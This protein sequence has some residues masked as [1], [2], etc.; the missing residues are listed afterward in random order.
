MATPQAAQLLRCSPYFPVADVQRSLEHYERVLGF[1]RE[2]V[3]GNP[4]EFAIVSRDGLAIMLRRVE[5]AARITPS[6]QQGGTWDAFFWVR[7]AEALH[8][9]LRRNGANIVYAPMLQKAY[10]MLEFAVRDLDG[11]VL[12]FGQQS[13]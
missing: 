2:Y 4:L 11:R 1:R 3:G 7:D 9:E 13:S 12:G 6:E 8:Q 5:S 10:G